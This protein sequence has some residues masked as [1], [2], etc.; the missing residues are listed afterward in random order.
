MLRKYFVF[1]L[2]FA[3]LVAP[4]IGAQVTQLDS[5][6]LRIITTKNA[7]EKLR[8]TMDFCNRW[9]SYN[10]DTLLK[11]AMQVQQ[12]AQSQNDPKNGIIGHYYYAAFLFQKGKLDSALIVV[13]EVI[14]NYKALETYNSYY[15]K[16]Y[17]LQGNILIR[18]GKQN[19]AIKQGYEELE[20]ATKNNDTV[21][22]IAA[23]ASLC[24]P[25]LLLGNYQEA[26]NWCLKALSMMQSDFYKK[27]MSFVYVNTAV[28]YH[29]LEQNEL[30]RN[31]YSMYY[32]KQGVHYAKQGENLSYQV[33]ALMCYA[34]LLT[35]KEQYQEADKACSEALAIQKK[36]G[37]Y[38][39]TNALMGRIA[40][41]Y[42]NSNQ[43]KKAL[44]IA[45]E[46][47]ALAMH[48]NDSSFLTMSCIIANLRDI[49][50]KMHD[51]KNLSEILQEQ[52]NLFEENYNENSSSELAEMQTKYE[53]KQKEATIIQQK[54]DMARKNYWIYGSLAALL[55]TF[56]IAFVL[57]KNHQKTSQ[58]KLKELAIEHERKTTEAISAAKDEERQRILA[59]LHDDVGGGLS[60]IRMVSDLM[61]TQHEQLQRVNEY[62]L[63]ISGITKDV[64]Q[65]MNTI[66]W[67]L[68]NEND[69][70]QN[71]C[72]YIRQYGY[73]FFE[74]S[75]I[76]FESKLPENLPEIELSGLQRKDIFLCVKEALNNISKHSEAKNAWVNISVAAKVL[77]I[78]VADNGKGIVSENQFG[79]G[80]KIMQ[81]R[82]LEL[83]GSINYVVDGGTKILLVIGI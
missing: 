6:K 32:A 40:Q 52:A 42:V 15:P 34:G 64:T 51:Y 47:K 4:K 31:D 77:S 11:Y 69:T 45:L 73:T 22:I 61:I 48:N 67:A 55:A 71:L 79:N 26:L 19:E 12:L 50:A 9:E 81:K 58:L 10:P 49:Y 33:T 1:F 70:L 28:V 30:E 74:N 59:D 35:N 23:M 83:G 72:E 20:Y 17:S 7:T 24:N 41:S 60:S 2:V 62:A 80:L 76:T 25:N 14:K 56:I 54:Y 8:A 39:Y 18:M 43:L 44:A 57:F 13:R 38:F 65:R 5:L 21:G 75:P 37:D 53:S 36:I 27:K 82:M 3:V 29:H 46:A 16:F 68:N 63:K 78:E 66:V